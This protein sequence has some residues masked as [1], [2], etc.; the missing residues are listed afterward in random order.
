MTSSRRETTPVRLDQSLME[1]AKTQGSLSTRTPPEQIQYWATI[2]KSVESLLTS[3]DLL[4]LMAETV[5]IQL[6][7]KEAPYIDPMSVLLDPMA[8][9]SNQQ[10]KANA[11]S[12]GFAYQASNLHPDKLE[13]IY[14]DGKIEV[15][16]FIGGVFTVDSDNA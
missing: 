12:V 6:V 7:H 8:S 10:V 15:G 9:A 2:G 16:T 11:M 13:K 4:S 3:A 5:E 1:A 14:P